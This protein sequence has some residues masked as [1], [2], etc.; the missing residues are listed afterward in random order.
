MRQEKPEFANDWLYS[1]LDNGKFA[2]MAWLGFLRARKLGVYHMRDVL[3]GGDFE[4]SDN[5]LKR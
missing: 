2:D 4:R 1:L 3:A 5:P